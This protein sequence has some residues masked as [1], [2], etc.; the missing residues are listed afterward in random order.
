VAVL[1]GNQANPWDLRP[2]E[3]LAPDYRVSAL[4][5]KGN[6][7][8]TGSLQLEQVP[9]QTAGSRLPLGPLKAPV[10]KLVGERYLRLEPLLTGAEIVHAAELGYWFSWQ[11]ARL[12]PKLGFKLA[13]TVWET[14]P[15]RDTYRNIRTR[16]YRRAVL[17]ATDLFL[18]T[19]ERARSSLLLEGVA[20]DRISVCPPGIEVERFAN[21]RQ[22]KPRPD[23]AHVVLSVGRL[24]WEKGHQD[25]L[26]AIA[27]LRRGAHPDLRGLIAGDGP[28]R[29]RLQAYARDLGIEAAIEFVPFTPNEKLPQLYARASCLVLASIPTMYWEE[30]FG[31]VLAEAMAAQLAIAASSCGA[32]PEVVGRSGSLFAPGDWL[33]LAAAL[34]AGPLARPAGFRQA[35]E[36][37]RMQLYSSSAATERL[38]AAY[39]ALI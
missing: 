2:W 26:R 8:D 14:I 31:M 30:Q 7:F 36:A 19:T 12:K 25:V 9:V 33:G 35:P 23:G 18:A 3:G 28:E 24:V 6:A 1:R 27:E 39:D 22:A 32:I 16:R 5:P 34:E 15:F 20:P 13:L 4:V 21:A 29:D 10:T 11:A 38:R 17:E 37:D